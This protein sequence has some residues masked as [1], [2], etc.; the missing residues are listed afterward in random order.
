MKQRRTVIIVTKIPCFLKR[1]VMTYQ[2]IIK[3]RRKEEQ[4]KS[5]D[6][7]QGNQEE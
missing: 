5:L 6:Q 4:G 1:T 2:L 3:R 7:D